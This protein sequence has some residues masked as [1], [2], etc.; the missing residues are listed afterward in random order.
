MSSNLLRAV[1]AVAGCAAIA[2]ASPALAAV[3]PLPQDAA[4][5]ERNRDTLIGGASEQ[6]SGF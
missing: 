5:M 3:V 1:A 2:G 6:A 4:T